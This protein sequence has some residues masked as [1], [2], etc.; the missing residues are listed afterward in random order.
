LYMER[1]HAYV[2]HTPQATFVRTRLQNAPPMMIA[3]TVAAA[4]LPEGSA[5]AYEDITDQIV[6]VV[7]AP[8]DIVC[9][10]AIATC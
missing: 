5:S 7:V 10:A 1:L 3:K 6:M 9:S 8:I 2:P 4:I